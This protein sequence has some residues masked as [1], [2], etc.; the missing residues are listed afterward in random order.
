MAIALYKDT[1]MKNQET[2]NREQ[3]VMMWKILLIIFLKMN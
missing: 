1:L 2:R 3:E